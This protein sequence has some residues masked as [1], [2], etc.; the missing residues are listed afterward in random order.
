MPLLY[1]FHSRPVIVYE[2]V[3]EGA[4]LQSSVDG[5]HVNGHSIQTSSDLPQVSPSTAGYHK[6]E[7]VDIS[8]S[9]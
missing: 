3:E 9:T 6:Y 7:V 2:A 5:V 1:I 8:T 4:Q